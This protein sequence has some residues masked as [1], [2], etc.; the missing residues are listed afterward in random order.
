MIGL[1]LPAA[2]KHNLWYGSIIALADLIPPD[3]QTVSILIP[4]SE[5]TPDVLPVRS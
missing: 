1:S 5:H 3:R 4:H 2:S